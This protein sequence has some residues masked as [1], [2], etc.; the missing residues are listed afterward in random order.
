MTL[1]VVTGLEQAG[2]HAGAA[3][4]ARWMRAGLLPGNTTAAR[5]MTHAAGV[6]LVGDQRYPAAL[7]S[8]TAAFYAD[9]G[10]YQLAA[11]AA[12]L[13]ARGDLDAASARYATL[14]R[15]FAH[16]TEGQFASQ[17]APYWIAR[18][19]EARGRR[20]EAIAAYAAFLRRF[21]LSI[22]ADEVPLAVPDARERLATLR[23]EPGRF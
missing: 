23:Q 6:V 10:S 14:A 12:G 4:L 19:H 2:D 18:H 1:F 20:P 7:D 11:L 9:S 13:A 3:A 22:P 5:A 8:L 17:L 16:G 21:P 15:D